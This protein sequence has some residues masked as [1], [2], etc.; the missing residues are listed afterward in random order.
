MTA[1]HLCARTDQGEFAFLRLY[2]DHR[3]WRP[4]YAN[5][6]DDLEAAKSGRGIGF[7]PLVVIWGDRTISWSFQISPWAGLNRFSLRPT[8]G[9]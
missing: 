4:I 5:T 1:Y 8:T 6:L 3:W 2:L 9:G 7:H